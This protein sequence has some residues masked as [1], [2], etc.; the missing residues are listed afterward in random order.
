MSRYELLCFLL[1]K[2]S[3]LHYFRTAFT[4]GKVVDLG[5]RLNSAWKAYRLIIPLWMV[6]CRI[7]A[8][9]SYLQYTVL[10]LAFDLFRIP[11]DILYRPAVSV[12]QR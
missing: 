9:F 4:A 11:T 5:G 10:S 6:S 8:V 1:L 3:F 12:S 2:A 7:Y